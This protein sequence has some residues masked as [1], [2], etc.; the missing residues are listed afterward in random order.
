MSEP[1]ARPVV[2]IAGETLG[3][4]DDALGAVLMR[5]FL[6]TLAKA[7]PR[8]RALV[9]QNGGVKHVVEGA[10]L[11]EDVRALAATGVEVLSCGTC[12]DWFGL[13]DRVAVGVVSNMH[14]IVTL[15]LRASSV[16]RP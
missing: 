12:L 9:F 15:L 6:K 3:Q 2:V 14:D 11:V 13:K 16:I 4:G 7:E 8:P 10:A 1:T 5:A